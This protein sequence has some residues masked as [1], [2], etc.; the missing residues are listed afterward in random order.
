MS[1]HY[2][3]SSSSSSSSSRV[4]A[5]PAVA[6]PGYHYMPDGSLMLDSEMEDM[7]SA[8][9]RNTSGRVQTLNPTAYGGK[10]PCVQQMSCA[11][12]HTWSQRHCNCMTYDELSGPYDFGGPT[13]GLIAPP[14]NVLKTLTV[15][16]LA[17]KL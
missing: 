12:G 8:N 5:T 2:G 4:A 6:P 13:G 7:S 11:P 16:I 14:L 9:Q 1:Y 17:L 15:K 10:E 3:S